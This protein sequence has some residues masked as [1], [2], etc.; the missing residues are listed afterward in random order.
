MAQV[1]DCKIVNLL[2]RPVVFKNAKDEVAKVLLP[3]GKTVIVW[4]NTKIPKATAEIAQSIN[5]IPVASHRINDICIQRAANGTRVGIPDPQP[6]VYYLVS[7]Y[8]ARNVCRIGRVSE[9][10]LYPM[11]SF[12]GG[13]Q[14]NLNYDYVCDEYLY[15]LSLGMVYSYRLDC[16]SD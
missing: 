8:I 14:P 10:L 11:H 2:G 13:P 4:S 5:K 16:F 7:E 9:D 1:S 3:E 12:V 15:I 6:L